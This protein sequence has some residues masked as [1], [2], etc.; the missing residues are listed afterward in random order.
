MFIDADAEAFGKVFANM[1]DEDQ[2]QV[3]RAMVEAMK[4]HPTQWDH[5]SIALEKPENSD[6]R[7]V[8]R[9]VLFP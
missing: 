2:V 9:N 6:V 8:L 3:F 7:D 5:I 4:A 1:D